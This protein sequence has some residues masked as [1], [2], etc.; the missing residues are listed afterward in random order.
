MELLV[1]KSGKEAE[2]IWWLHRRLQQMCN[3]FHNLTSKQSAGYYSWRNIFW[4][5]Y[6]RVLLS[7][8]CINLKNLCAHL[9][10][11]ILTIPKHPRLAQFDESEAKLWCSKEDRVLLKLF[12]YSI[13]GATSFF[14]VFSA[15]HHQKDDFWGCFGIVR[16]SS[17]W[18]AQ[19]F[20][21]L[22]Q[23]WLR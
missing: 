23:K 15:N 13:L 21:K 1:E 5:S 12:W 6:R 10:E 4:E 22:M 14:A 19:E 11:E 2:C 20:S 17:W 16:I 9:Q 8:G 18:W 3:E 7:L